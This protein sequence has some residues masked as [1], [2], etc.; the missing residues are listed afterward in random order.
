VKQSVLNYARELA[1]SNDK[2]FAKRTVEQIADWILKGGS[3]WGTTAD[4]YARDVAEI[5]AVVT[6]ERAKAKSGGGK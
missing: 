2:F 6:D 3:F 1:R 5:V 4:E